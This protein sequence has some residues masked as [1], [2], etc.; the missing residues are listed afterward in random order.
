MLSDTLRNRLRDGDILVDEQ[1]REIELGPEGEAL[2][3]EM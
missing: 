3:E 1:I 2:L